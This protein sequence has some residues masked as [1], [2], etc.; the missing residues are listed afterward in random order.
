MVTQGNLSIAWLDWGKV[1]QIPYLVFSLLCLLC[2]H[3]MV[4]KQ[5][6]FPSKFLPK[7]NE[8]IEQ[9]SLQSINNSSTWCVVYDEILNIPFIL[10]LIQCPYT[11]LTLQVVGWTPGQHCQLNER[12]QYWLIWLSGGGGVMCWWLGWVIFVVFS[13]LYVSVIL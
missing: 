9:E 7:K 6:F 12:S 4:H 1:K 10:L 8:Y 13:K 3:L 5:L 11:R 2:K